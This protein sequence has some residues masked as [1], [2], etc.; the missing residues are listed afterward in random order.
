MNL[1]GA[2][3]LLSITGPYR[4]RGN[5]LPN[6]RPA[7][8][9]TLHNVASNISDRILAMCIGVVIDHAIPRTASREAIGVMMAG[10]SSRSKRTTKDS[11]AEGIMQI[12]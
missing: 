3:Q 10:V 9:T 5:G 8:P 12:P 11:A 7:T 1:T 2:G 4:Q 6:C